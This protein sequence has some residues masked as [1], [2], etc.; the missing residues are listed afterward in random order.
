MEVDTTLFA[1]ENRLPNDHF[2]SHG[3]V[4][5]LEFSAVLPIAGVGRGVG[6][7]PRW[8]ALILMVLDEVV[9]CP[10]SLVPTQT[11]GQKREEAGKP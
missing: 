2:P 5:R 6:R 9:W 8:G 1:E 7:R 4:V 10:A 11:L 3:V